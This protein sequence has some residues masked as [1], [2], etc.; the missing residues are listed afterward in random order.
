MRKFRKRPLSRLTTG[1]GIVSSRSEHRLNSIRI[2]NKKSSCSVFF[3]VSAL[4][5][6]NSIWLKCLCLAKRLLMNT[7]DRK[8]RAR[9]QKHCTKFSQAI[10]RI[11]ALNDS[12]FTDSASTRAEAYF[13]RL[14]DCFWDSADRQHCCDWI[15]SK[16][17]A[18]EGLHIFFDNSRT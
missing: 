7:S 9:L 2:R 3:F 1:N 16:F 5:K 15:L 6:I 10:L 13:R 8:Q 11:A 12:S 17:R 14:I 18:V 4:F